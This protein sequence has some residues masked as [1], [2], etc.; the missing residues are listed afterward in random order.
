MYRFTRGR[1]ARPSIATFNRI[2]HNNRRSPDNV[3][4]LQR[5]SFHNSRRLDAL[6]PYRLADIGEGITECRIVSWSVKPGDYIQQFDPICEV[7]SDK[8]TVEI[9]SRFEGTIKTLHY[10]VDDM[11]PVGSVGANMAS[12]MHQYPNTEQALVDIETEDV[13]D[14]HDLP[15]GSGDRLLEEASVTDTPTASETPL[16]IATPAVRHILKDL[17]LNI[18][19]IT[20][21][22]KGGRVLKED[23]QR[24][25]AAIGITPGSQ[26]IQKASEIDRDPGQDRR[27]PLSLIQTQMFHSMTRSLSIPHLLYT[28]T[29]DLTDLTAMRKRT[30]NDRNLST[31]LG[32]ED[33]APKLSVLPFVL[34]ALSQA[35]TAYPTVNSIL[36]TE[37]DPAKPHLVLKTAHNFGVAVDTPN[38]LLVPVVR[39]VQDRS[40][41]SIAAEI[42]RLSTLAKAGRLSPNDMTGAT[43]VVSNIGS[44]GGDAI[45]PV[46]L[47]PMTAILAIGRATQVPAFATDIH[48]QE[49]IVKK[50]Q[51]TLS[52]SA[53]HRVLD[54]A[55][56]AR[57]AQSVGSWLENIDALA[58]TLK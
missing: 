57:C 21:T 18:S 23:V 26:P 27:I 8:A 31:L 10:E 55:T 25:A 32:A 42:S 39:N 34:K 15:N 12:F 36:D 7:Q 48:G 54:G 3:S 5:C 24:H 45:A 19:A 9:T 44:I 33:S 11:A 37:N 38:G 52:W 29:V 51:V 4:I 43:L 30:V 46:I 2:V 56:V 58:L 17:G 16:S 35:V 6:T 40:I 49:T 1:S 13:E 41:I 47:S 28:H 50:E 20:G 14:D 22:G 53:D